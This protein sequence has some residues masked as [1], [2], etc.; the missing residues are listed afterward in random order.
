MAKVTYT[1]VTSV[2]APYYRMLRFIDGVIDGI[3]TAFPGMAT[4]IAL[5]RAE[6]SPDGIYLLAAG[7]AASTSALRLW[8]LTPTD[9]FVEINLPVTASARTIAGINWLTNTHIIYICSVT[10]VWF[11]VLNRSTNIVTW[12]NPNTGAGWLAIVVHP[13]GLYAMAMRQNVAQ[14]FVRTGDTLATTA[15]SL[16]APNYP[17]T[18]GEFSPVGDQSAFCAGEATAGST[19]S[20]MRRRSAVTTLATAGMVFYNNVDNVFGAR[21]LKWS[22]KHPVG[23]AASNNAPYLKWVR[24]MYEDYPSSLRFCAASVLSGYPAFPTVHNALSEAWATDAGGTVLVAVN[25][26]TITTGRVRGFVFSLSDDTYTE[27]PEIAALFND[28]SA[29]PSWITSGPELDLMTAPA[30]IYDSTI[31][32]LFEETV[33]LSS[34]K[35]ALIS[36]NSFDATDTTLTEALGGNEVSGGSWPAGGIAVNP[37]VLEQIA[38]GDYA[39]LVDIPDWDFS[40]PGSI[41]FRAGVLYDDAHADKRPFGYINFGENKTAEQFQRME[42]TS[43]GGVFV[44]F[45]NDA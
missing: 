17:L 26:N 13:D 21:F 20:H 39:V 43:P 24:V 4:P 41:T 11:G 34:I 6:F 42:F 10:G 40:L 38:N 19:F 45:T 33:N 25:S 1:F 29:I 27:I 2:T 22:R 3:V 44:K 12:T 15:G 16:A 28:W 9:E 7:T 5:G 30:A 23:Y 31:A 32:A 18:Q 8:R 36:T 35:F 37:V 14:W